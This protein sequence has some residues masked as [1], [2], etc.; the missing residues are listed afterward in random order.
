MLVIDERD[1]V[2]VQTT[3]PQAGHKFARC[4]IACGQP[5]I[6]YGYPIGFATCD[7]AKGEWVHSHNLKTGLGETL[8]IHT[9]L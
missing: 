9:A 3:G 7:I 6:K 1:N 2:S 4:E 8:V 5:V